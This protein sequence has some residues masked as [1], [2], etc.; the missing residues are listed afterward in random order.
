MSVNQTQSGVYEPVRNDREFLGTLGAINAE[1]VFDVNG[2]A[3]IVCELRN[4]FSLS[5]QFA[6]SLDGTNYID[7]PAIDL[8][9]QQYIF[10]TAL[11]VSSSFRLYSIPLFQ[12]VRKVRVRCTAFTSGSAV[13]TLR[14]SIAPSVLLALPFPSSLAV[15]MT[16]AIST[17]GTL[18][19]PAAGSGLYHY[20]TRLLIQKFNAALLVAAAAPVIVTTGNLPGS[21]AF[22]LPADGASQGTMNQEVLEPS[23]PL[24]STS[25]NVA[26]TIVCPAITSVIWRVTADY[27][28]GA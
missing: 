24:K 7:C 13:V 2:E 23:Q 14:G 25:P 6:Y 19:L 21:R 5:I 12:G 4:T 20:V 28:I 10:S 11:V 18:T 15:T 9:S 27:Y 22:S 3:S 1:V 8:Q 17:S 26:T 16:T